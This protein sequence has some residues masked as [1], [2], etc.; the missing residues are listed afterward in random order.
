[1]S[2]KVLIV[3]DEILIRMLYKNHLEKAGYQL[4]TARSAEEGLKIARAEQPAV[5]IL[6]IIMTGA[7][8][9]AALRELKSHD[10]TRSIPVI[11][12]TA[13]ITRAHHET[14]QEA[15]TSGAAA[16][17]TKP[18]SPAQLVSEI[19]KLVPL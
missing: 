4:L 15:A 14:R 5:V 6:D 10:E 11:I 16:F 9:L 18:I 13:T 1:M 12:F 2:P 3:D 7:D 17:L 19:Q 8:G